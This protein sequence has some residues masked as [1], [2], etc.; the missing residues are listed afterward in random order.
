MK[1]K[2]VY[3]S[4]FL[5]CFVWGCAPKKQLPSL[6]EPTK[7]P[8]IMVV[9]DQ[10][11]YNSAEDLYAE[12]SYEA[13]RDQYD[14]YIRQFP[15]G[16]AAAMVLMRLGEIHTILKEYEKARHAYRKLTT[17]HPQHPRVSDAMVGILNAFV[18]EEKYNE[19]I[20]YSFEFPEKHLTQNQLLKKET[21]VGDAFLATG[22]WM[23]AFYFY[24]L[25]YNQ[26]Q[27]PDRERMLNK[28][29]DV[30]PRLNRVHTDHLLSRLE[31]PMLEGHLLYHMGLLHIEAGRT[32]SAIEVLTT[33]I[34]RYPEHDQADAP[35][36]KRAARKRRFQ[37]RQ[38]EARERGAEPAVRRIA[39]RVDGDRQVVGSE[40]HHRADPGR[41]AGRGEVR[42]HAV[43]RRLA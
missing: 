35:V 13:A 41:V 11:L 1:T 12:K 43:Q 29:I 3:L 7:P 33:L 20:E 8:E 25:V 30:L 2:L 39:N 34:D 23:D 10:A 16:D 15:Q 22:S 28:L 6:L 4:L 21:L 26:S 5:I 9:D 36:R 38:F 19:A 27:G 24:S 17:E 32:E 42:D 40:P 31:D 18:M 14:A 37:R